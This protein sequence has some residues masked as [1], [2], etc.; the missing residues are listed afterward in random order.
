MKNLKSLK[1]MALGLGIFALAPLASCSNE[2][3][4]KA[5]ESYVDPAPEG[6]ATVNIV[7]PNM[8][9]NSS[10]AGSVNV[11]DAEASINN[12]DLWLC[13]FATS[14]TDNTAAT[15]VIQLT[16]SNRD[17]STVIGKDKDN[18][19]DWGKY[20]VQLKEGTYRIYVVA[21]VNE[22]LTTKISSSTTTESTV[23]DMLLNFGTILSTTSATKNKGIEETHLPMAC[24]N[25]EIKKGTATTPVSEGKFVVAKSATESD[26][27]IY[28]ELT[29]LCAKVR[30]TVLFDV[31][32]AENFTSQAGI[33]YG[34]ADAKSV[35]QQTYFDFSK[36]A[37]AEAT[38]KSYLDLPGIQLNKYDM[39]V[40]G[41]A[42]LFASYK[43]LD[44]NATAPLANFSTTKTS[45]D[46]TNADNDKKRAWQGIVYLPENKETSTNKTYIK[47]NPATGANISLET[48]KGEFTFSEGLVRGNYYDIVANLITPNTYFVTVNVYV[49][50]KPW[51]YNPSA[52][53]NW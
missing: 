26:N 18:S 45:W 14:D 7:I 36:D 1:F 39:S 2:D 33:D 11:T 23:T 38:N 53:V 50:V 9:D 6:Y 3:N 24:M 44:G 30:Y 40:S 29:L 25:T 49:K 37:S 42:D 5:P 27:N 47:L 15:Q 20:I 22:Y 8:L 12:D 28:A 41:Q 43:S 10:R 16:S 19:N 35:R 32:T 46:D 34:S 31:E 21:N 52:V 17:G 48:G 51:I 4:V 13:A